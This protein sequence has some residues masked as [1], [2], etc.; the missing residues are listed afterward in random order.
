MALYAMNKTE[1]GAC[2]QC[3]RG[4]WILCERPARP[5]AG[6]FGTHAQFV[7]RRDTMCFRLPESVSFDVGAVLLDCVGTPYR[8]IRRLAVNGGDTVLITGQGP[9][10]Q[11][12]AMICAFLGARVVTAELNDARREHGSGFGVERALNPAT[13][14][15]RAAVAE[16]TDGRGV[17]VAIDCTGLAEPQVLCLDAVATGGR[18]GL[19]GVKASVETPLRVQDQLLM[20]EL[21]VLGS[22]YLSQADYLDLLDLVDRGLPVERLI[23]HRFALADAAE[24]FR[25]SFGGDGSKVIIDP[26]ADAVDQ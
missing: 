12:A 3:L 9:V 7:L 13:D 4:D 21:T 8:A 14:D 24:A 2:R 1:C 23:T 6:F 19:V 5:H 11:A 18:V 15:V 25:T 20:K 17:D 16:L 22:W 26:W 10:G